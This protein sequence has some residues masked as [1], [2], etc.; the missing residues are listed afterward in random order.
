MWSF[1]RRISIQSKLTLVF[2]LTTTIALLL[3]CAALFTYERT[4]FKEA[5]QDNLFTLAKIVGEN[6]T[7]AIEFE[8]PEEAT[9]ILTALRSEPQIVAARIFRK[10]GQ[11]F[12]DFSPFVDFIRPGT[13]QMLPKSP[14]LGGG[15]VSE[16]DY[17]GFFSPIV[18]KATKETIGVIYLRA[19]LGGIRDSLKTYASIVSIVLLISILVTFLISARLVRFL[20]DPIRALANTA[21]KVSEKKDYS[22]RAEKKSEDELGT[23]TDAFNQMLAQIQVQDTAL[24]RSNEDLERR[25]E[26]RTRELQ[27]LQR[28]NEL[29]LNS[30]GEGIYGLDMTGRISFA[31]PTAA[32]TTG[33]AIEELVGTFEHSIM[34]HSSADGT[35]YTQENCP[36]CVSFR[37]GKIQCRDNDVFQRKDGS[38]F[39]A[40]FVRTPIVENEKHIG[41]VILFKDISE[42]KQAEEAL[43]RQTREL[44]RSNAELEQFAYVASHDLQEPLRMVSNYTQLLGRR[45]KDKLDSDAHEFIAFSVD[46]AIRMQGLINDLLMYSRV[47]TQ[48]K[49]FTKVDT[50]AS[51]GQAIINLRGAIEAAHALVTHDD[52][53]IVTAD[54]SQLIQ[55]FQNLIGNAI[56]FRGSPPPSVHISAQREDQQHWVFSVRDNGIGIE[57]QYAERIFVIF[58]RLHGHSEYPGTGIGLSI[59]KKIVDRH[60]GRI[61]VESKVGEG[62]TFFFTIPIRDGHNKV[63]YGE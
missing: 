43:A 6:S 25:V 46:G 27:Q 49:K 8:N 12:V 36:I 39:H 52:L 26:V 10:R 40:E 29:I 42:R 30:A 35:V 2:L 38:T 1:L 37:E 24:R 56:K 5:L 11:P 54:P 62:A 13:N 55:L 32:K 17:L 48:G 22:V 57:P 33:W 51:V 4:I 61:W 59:C 19:D 20:S 34:R 3:A 45:Y 47:G 44:A 63:E 9:A 28:Q 15:F 23:F 21:K 16:K 58:Q 50:S 53:P 60:G 31:N 14:K 7:V 41:A 18:N